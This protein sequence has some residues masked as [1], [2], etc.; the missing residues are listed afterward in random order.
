VGGLTKALLLALPTVLLLLACGGSDSGAGATLSPTA[1]VVS[2][3]VGNA[4]TPAGTA[5]AAIPSPTIPVTATPT[6]RPTAPAKATATGAATPLASATTALDEPTAATTQTPGGA[7]SDNDD[8]RLT[9]ALP[10][11]DD[12]PSGW[13][14]SPADDSDDATDAAFCDADAVDFDFGDSP[15][16]DVSFTSGDFGPFFTVSV[17]AVGQDDAQQFMQQVDAA[18]SCQTW[19]D[20]SDDPP[21]TWTISE[22]SLPDLGDGVVARKLH[23]DTDFAPLT[24]DLV[25]VRSGGFVASIANLSLGALDSQLTVDQ[26]QRLVKALE[27]EFPQG[28]P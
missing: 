5:S 3:A 20:T 21:T 24:A 6:A 28:M 26:A 1:T 25:F 2:Q 14:I 11:L 19:I 17:A 10:T 7:S 8:P 9:K 15:S 16:A 4:T 13:T 18:L 27:S 23:A 12:M 22:L